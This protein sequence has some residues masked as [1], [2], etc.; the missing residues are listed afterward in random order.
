MA[1]QPSQALFLA[2]ELVEESVLIVQDVLRSGMPLDEDGW[3]HDATELLL[4]LG[5]LWERPTV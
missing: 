4:R 1:T 3:K 2:P 5:P